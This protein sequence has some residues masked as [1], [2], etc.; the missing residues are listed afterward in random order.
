MY[1]Y[2]KSSQHAIT[3]RQTESLNT[4]MYYNYNLH[5]NYF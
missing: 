2:D 1:V 4:Y 5:V 3:S